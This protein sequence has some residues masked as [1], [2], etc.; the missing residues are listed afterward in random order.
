MQTNSTALLC[1]HTNDKGELD[2]W[3]EQQYE[4]P[5]CKS[6]MCKEHSR[7]ANVDGRPRRYCV[8]CYESPRLSIRK[9]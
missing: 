2:C 4:C 5:H 3:Q 8:T 7:L 6:W 9:W 1:W